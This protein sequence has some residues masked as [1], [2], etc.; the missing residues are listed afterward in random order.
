MKIAAPIY[1]D[2]VIAPGYHTPPYLTSKPE[3]THHRLTSRDKFMIIASDGLWDMMSPLQAVRIVGEHMR[4][5]VVLNHFKLPKA[6]MKLKDINY[7]LLQRK[8]CF[9]IKPTDQN[10]ATYLLRNALGGTDFG[11]EHNTLSRYLSLPQEIVRNFR[12]DIT[13]TVVYFNSECLRRVLP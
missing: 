5:K 10:A 12:D 3:V 1:G 7:L 6:R 8:E 11:F 2:S 13:I 9:N 4:G